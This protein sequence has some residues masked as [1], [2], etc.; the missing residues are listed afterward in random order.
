MNAQEEEQ[1]SAHRQNG[2]IDESGN[3]D[4]IRNILFGSQMRDYDDRFQKLEERLA[5]EAGELRSDLQRQLQ[6]L[7][8]FMKGE[9]ESMT[10]R[11]KTEQSER[12][13][14]VQQLPAQLA[15][16]CEPSQACHDSGT[17]H[18]L[19]ES[20]ADDQPSLEQF[21]SEA[22]LMAQLVCISRGEQTWFV[23]RLLETLASASTCEI[24]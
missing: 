5:R 12:I 9:T 13:Q 2:T 11:V 22:R 14:A 16:E 20:L 24:R 4:R 23:R 15:Q 6:A 1:M 3:V 21:L 8:T 19:K 17:T 10:N 7:E 18:A